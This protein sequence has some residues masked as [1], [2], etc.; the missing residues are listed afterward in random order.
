MLLLIYFV[1]VLAGILT[2]ASAVW[3]IW[4]VL[5]SLLFIF[6]VIFMILIIGGAVYIGL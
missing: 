3:T 6:A 1:V 2:F 4:D 5:S